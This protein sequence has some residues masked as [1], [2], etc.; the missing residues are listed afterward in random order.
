MFAPPPSADVEQDRARVTSEM[1]QIYTEAESAVDD[2]IERLDAAK[3]WAEGEMDRIT[4]KALQDLEDGVDPDVVERQL[5]IDLEAVM[6]KAAAP[7]FD[8]RK[9]APPKPAIAK[10]PTTELAPPKPS[11]VAAP[12]PIV[13]TPSVAPEVAA[14]SPRPGC[15]C[16]S[17]RAAH[18]AP[19]LL[20][21]CL[22]LACA[23]RR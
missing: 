18:P 22:A 9:L 1:Q 19:A 16:R 12:A 10:P 7:G 20:V 3:K 14:D 5:P 8:P 6:K 15:G 11:P 21:L 4:A 2:E 23:R 17:Q 13:A